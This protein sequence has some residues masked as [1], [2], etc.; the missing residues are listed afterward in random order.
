MPSRAE[1][2]SIDRSGRLRV[3]FAAG[4]SVETTSVEAGIVG[5]P[6]PESPLSNRRVVVFAL[7]LD[8]IA[9]GGEGVTATTGYAS[10]GSRRNSADNAHK[11]NRDQYSSRFQF[12]LSQYLTIHVGTSAQIFAAH[13]GAFENVVVLELA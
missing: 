4:A 8:Q 13:T 5:A 9:F 3:S 7:P 11:S 12:M 6:L 1:A 10:R 2:F